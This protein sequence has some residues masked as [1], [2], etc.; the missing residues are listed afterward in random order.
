MREKLDKLS[1]ILDIPSPDPEDARRQ[2][3][4]AKPAG[5][6]KKPISEHELRSLVKRLFQ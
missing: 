1:N 5:V 2:L 4:Q 6:L 3:E